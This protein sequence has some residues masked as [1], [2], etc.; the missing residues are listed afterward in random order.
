MP[1]SRPRIQTLARGEAVVKSGLDA[2][3]LVLL[4]ADRHWL[5]TAPVLLPEE[6]RQ[7]GRERFLVRT[8]R[9]VTLIGCDSRSVLLLPHGQ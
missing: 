5:V 7:P 2:G 9:N 6:V 8:L 4:Q 3:N 1:R